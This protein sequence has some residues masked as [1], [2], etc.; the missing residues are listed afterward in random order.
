MLLVP[1]VTKRRGLRV[2][3]EGHRKGVRAEEDTDGCEEEKMAK[4]YFKRCY[5]CTF[6]SFSLLTELKGD[7]TKHHTYS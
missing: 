1:N 7:C 3:N 5:K 6:L 2:P 4:A